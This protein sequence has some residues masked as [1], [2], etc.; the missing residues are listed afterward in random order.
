MFIYISN[1]YAAVGQ[2][3][4]PHI[5][6]I[7]GGCSPT[8]PTV[9]ILESRYTTQ[10]HKCESFV[11]DVHIPTHPM[12]CLR[13]LVSQLNLFAHDAT[14][15]RQERDRPISHAQSMSTTMWRASMRA[16]ISARSMPWSSKSHT[17]MIRERTLAANTPSTCSGEHA[18]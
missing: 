15:L 10:R 4:Q 3:T 5:L 7:Y 9:C 1:S 13:W 11:I 2:P 18:L 6:H 17:A 8:Q 12:S 14:F 16:T